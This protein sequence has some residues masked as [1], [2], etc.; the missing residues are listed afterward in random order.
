MTIT[1][2]EQTQQWVAREASRL[3]QSAEDFVARALEE[4][5]LG[6]LTSAVLEAEMTKARESGAPR[7]VTAQWW[8]DLEAEIAQELK[9]SQTND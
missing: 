2:S 3:G 8:A 9:L 7:R 4:Q 1:L 5:A 6:A